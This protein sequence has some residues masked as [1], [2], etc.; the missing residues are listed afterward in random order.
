MRFFRYLRE[1][2][3]YNAVSTGLRSFGRYISGP[4][5]GSRPI[6][7]KTVIDYDMARQLYRNDSADSN[8]GAGFCRPIIDRAVE[9]IDLPIVSSDNE[10][11]DADV[12][13]AIRTY[14]APQLVEMFRNSMRDSKT[15]VRVWQPVL[16]DPLTTV[17]ERQM[18]ALD[19]V[20]PERVLNAV[21][22]PQNPRALLEITIIHFVEMTDPV[23][24][25]DDPPRGTRA[26]TKEHEI[27]EVI[28]P[29]D[30][31]YYDRTDREWLTDWGRV[32]PYGFVPMLEVFNE[33]DSAL[34][35]GQSDLE[36]VYPFVKSFHEVLRQT[37]QA[38]QYHSMPKLRFKVAD[39]L[40]FLTNNFP[41]TVDENGNVVPGS[42]INWKGRE[43]L[44]IGENEDVGFIEVKS[45]LGDSKVLLEFLI[46]C[47]SIASETPE[48]A[49][50]RVEG[51][52]SEGAMNAQ[53]IPFEKRI[54]RKR[55]NFQ[56]SIQMIVKMMLAIN[57][58]SP[59]RVE[60]TWP[61]I[62]VESIVAMASAMQQMVLSFEV[63]LDRQ[64]ISDNTARE[65]IKVFRLF[66][67]MK[68]PQEEATDAKKNFEPTVQPVLAPEKNGKPPKLP[69]PPALPARSGRN[70][71]G[72]GN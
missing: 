59:E 34:G 4:F 26:M 8:L 23:Q 1:M 24:P 14:W 72:A 2:V 5:F 40:G 61:E 41:E 28:T 54:E 43:V 53:T 69:Q 7:D 45:V 17:A 12:N 22:N 33:Y 63:L 52:V 18:C 27:W 10:Q 13:S 66:A 36:S 46:D 19:I 25:H 70:G 49:F 16:D 57:N 47:I 6:A 71:G 42:A 51:G 39:F 3:Y 60:V 35:G 56:E 55:R 15:W 21:Y 30:H 58:Q 38:H 68:P 9:F 48:W 64:L 29:T 62:R 67:K 37:L 32:N 31:R 50:M 44:F 65:A 11:R 20:E